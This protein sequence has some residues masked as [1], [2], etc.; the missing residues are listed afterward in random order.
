MHRGTTFRF[1]TLLAMLLPSLSADVFAS[2]LEEGATGPVPVESSL[3]GALAKSATWEIPAIADV[4][5]AFSDWTKD[6]PSQRVNDGRLQAF[7]DSSID[8]IGSQQ[9]L[10]AIVDGIALLR[11]DVRQ[12]RDQ[13][14]RPFDG[15]AVPEMDYRFDDPLESDFVSDHVG[16]FFGRWLAQHRFYDESLQRLRKVPETVLDPATLLFYR[17]LME[18]QLLEKEAC[19]ATIKRLLEN[20]EQIPRRYATIGRLMLADME[21]LKEDSLDEISRLMADAGRRTGLNRSGQRVIEQEKTVIEKLDKLI[22]E[23]E[24]QQQ[25]QQQQMQRSGGSGQ[26]PQGNIRASQG[27]N[28]ATGDVKKKRQ[29]D[30][31]QWGNLPPAQRAAALAEMSRD[32]PPH[33]RAV[34]EE[35]FKKLADDN[36]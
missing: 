11:D 3:E 28:S 12:M 19:L 27:G 22:E 30:G 20:R 36:R 2:K 29:E 9:R 5:A 33:Y 14:E 18:H 10:D 32:M 21:P 1:A 31:G 15:V 26:A 16:L 17:G 25:Q 8:A 23:K 35:Y 24:N 6:Q 7:L 13:L 34:I 4:L